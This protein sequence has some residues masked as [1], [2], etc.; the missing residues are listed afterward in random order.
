MK[1]CMRQELWRKRTFSSSQK[2]LESKGTRLSWWA[3]G[4]GQ[5]NILLYSTSDYHTEFT[6]RACNDDHRIDSF[7]RELKEFREDRF[8]SGYQSWKLSLQSEGYCLSTPVASW[9]STAR[10]GAVRNELMLC[11]LSTPRLDVAILMVDGPCYGGAL[12]DCLL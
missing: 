8:V 7:E 6:A 5:K 1:S 2:I 11:L 12:L 10:E 3:I 4:L 9:K